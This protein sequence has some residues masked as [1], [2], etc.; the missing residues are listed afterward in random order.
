MEKYKVDYSKQEN[1][2]KFDELSLSE[3]QVIINQAQEEALLIMEAARKISGKRGAKEIAAVD[4]KAA[5]QARTDEDLKKELL[6]SFMQS[7][8]DKFIDRIFDK[9][10]IESLCKCRMTAEQE[11]A[12]DNFARRFAMYFSSGGYQE[13]L[14]EAMELYEKVPSDIARE[15][16]R[17][18]F[19][20]NFEVMVR[21]NYDE[22]RKILKV[23]EEAKDNLKISDEFIQQ[24]SLEG[25]FFSLYEGRTDRYRDMKEFVGVPEWVREIPEMK[26]AASTHITYNRRM[27]KELRS[28]YVLPDEEF[29][30]ALTIGTA[31][32]MSNYCSSNFPDNEV[33]KKEL[34]I[35]DSYAKRCIELGIVLSLQ[36]DSITNSFDIIKK[37]GVSDKVL[38]T[39]EIQNAAKK[40]LYRQIENKN[41]AKF[42]EMI[43]GYNI[44]RSDVSDTIRLAMESGNEMKVILMLDDIATQY[45]EP[46]EQEYGLLF[47]KTNIGIPSAT[48]YT[49][50]KKVFEENDKIK[51]EGFVG[52][53]KAKIDSIISNQPQTEEI[54]KQDGYKE[55]IELMYPNNVGSW[56]GF[57]TNE[58]CKD[59][60]ADLAGFKIKPVYEI[61]LGKGSEMILREGADKDEK[62]LAQ[63][64]KNI[65]NTQ[66]EFEKVGFDKSKMF[67]L[68][69]QTLE[70]E[71]A[72]IDYIDIFKTREEKIFSLILENMVNRISD[73]KLKEILISYY[74]IVDED[75]RAYLESTRDQVAQSR[76][77]D[78]A[79]LGELREFFADR[80]V[81]LS[82]KITNGQKNEDIL[83]ILPGYY[84]QKSSLEKNAQVADALNRANINYSDYSRH[85]DGLKKKGNEKAV[86]AFI[87]NEQ[88]KIARLIKTVTGSSADPETID[89][90]KF[91]I[92][93]LISGVDAGK[94]GDYDDELFSNY[95][96]G[97]SQGIFKDEI[98]LI[99]RELSKYKP[100]EDDKKRK[101][102]R[103][104]EC[105]ITKNHTSAHARGVG[106]VCVSGDNPDKGENCIWNLP[107][108]FQ[109]VLRDKTTK[110]CQGLVLLHHFEE[111]G[112]KILTASFNPSSTYLYKVDESELFNGLMKQLA[113]FASDNGFDYI[114]T[115]T[116]HGMRTNR[117]GGEFEKAM[118]KAIKDKDA[119]ISFSESKTFSFHPS[120]K[121]QNLDVIWEK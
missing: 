71:T 44:K 61:K 18:T 72:G 94:H 113:V 68:F 89:V 36:K 33:F 3:R 45:F 1:Q 93:E 70:K 48:F 21:G 8:V 58:S 75:I 60:S 57:R 62:A 82:R 31:K 65:R 43:E 116:G 103:Q 2:A 53:F 95:L 67:E 15:I 79:N 19:S 86:S 56:T 14:N 74:F 37:F 17:K 114:C 10:A 120:Y 84:N 117:T 118:D 87:L 100:G 30:D 41:G 24:S 4:Y 28:D 12:A 90:A 59:R 32:D 55:L 80:M 106:G 83:K 29:F 109:M 91:S 52:Q 42:S 66:A 46:L 38:A 107:N 35:P 54:T 64:E 102:F 69:D 26:H 101:Q 88:K 27:A 76:N 105:I 5:F 49:P 96:L 78:Y 92:E 111:N 77:K 99:D 9:Q 6:E 81:D 104:L 112:K 73:D 115:S 7:A 110:I 22:S 51:L 50:F 39:A 98:S 119:K 34:N 121:M 25:V 23:I 16:V 85:L 97:V 40:S 13:Y 47:Y 63:I 20:F 108:Y 11:R